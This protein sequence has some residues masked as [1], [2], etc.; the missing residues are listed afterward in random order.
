M[1]AG[2]F[3]RPAGKPTGCGLL[4]HSASPRP[5]GADGPRT[6]GAAGAGRRRTESDGAAPGAR[7]VGVPG[8]ERRADVGTSA[9][10]RPDLRIDCDAPMN[11]E[12]PNGKQSR[13]PFSPPVRRSSS[14]RSV[15]DDSAS[16]RGMLG[17]LSPRH[18]CSLKHIK[19]S[20]ME[21]ALDWDRAK[22][23]K[24]FLT[25]QRRHLFDSCPRNEVGSRKQ[26]VSS[27]DLSDAIMPGRASGASTPTMPSPLGRRK[28][29]SIASTPPHPGA[30]L[31]AGHTPRRG[32][33]LPPSAWLQSGPNTGTHELGSVTWT[34]TRSRASSLDAPSA[35]SARSRQQEESLTSPRRSSW[36]DMKLSSSPPSSCGRDWL[37]LEQR[38]RAS[39]CLDSSSFVTGLPMSSTSHRAALSGECVAAPPRW[40]SRKKIGSCSPNSMDSGTLLKQTSRSQTGQGAKRRTWRP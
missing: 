35:V 22:E 1:T 7:T 21:A 33:R 20:T 16:S 5:N 30:R 8:P 18:G 26:H 12:R 2:F 6:D 14:C 39:S 9:T 32:G 37:S 29:D 13:V 40:S 27:K 24:P 23:A 34:P 25:A 28:L 31:P 11:S 4:D 3:D 19:G 15:E 36:A 17:L 38:P 10:R